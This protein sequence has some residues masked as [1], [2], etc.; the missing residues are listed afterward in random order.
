[1]QRLALG[2]GHVVGH[3]GL[4]AVLAAAD[5]EEVVGVGVERV[6]QAGGCQIEA[7]PAPF[8]AGPQHGDV[9]A[10]G[11][12]VHQLGVEAADPQRR[13]TITSLPT[14][15]GVGSMTWRASGVRP[16]SAASS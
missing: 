4:V 7:E 12:D 3:R 10:V 1:M 8:A 11:V 5:E 2:G 13:H 14:W 9:A 6:A 16:T 15:S